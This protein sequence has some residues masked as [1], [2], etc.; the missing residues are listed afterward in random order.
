MHRQIDLNESE[1]RLLTSVLN[2]ISDGVMVSNLDGRF[3]LMNPAA[4]R[5]TGINQVDE[6]KD[7][8]TLFGC[9]SPDGRTLLDSDKLP[10]IR[11]MHGESTDEIEM[12][13]KNPALS[14]AITIEISGKPLLSPDGIGHIGGIIVFR[15]ITSRR[16]IEDEIR[17]SQEELQQFAYIAAHDLQEPLRTITGYLSLLT[18][19][20][21]SLLQESNGEKYVTKAV[22]GARRMQTL[23]EDLLTYAR[24]SSKQHLVGPVNLGEII[25]TVMADLSASIH[26][27][28]TTIKMQKMPRV[29]ADRSQLR[30]LFQNIISNSIKYRAKPPEIEITATPYRAFYKISVADNGIGFE[31]EYANRIFLIFQRLHG[32]TQY[33]GTGI[34]LAICKRIIEKHGGEI[35]VESALGKGTT[36]HFTLPRTPE[37]GG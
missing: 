22:E 37:D 25:A 1:L 13:L 14:T 4:R 28:G 16:N 19:R 6:N 2:S 20:C 24:I 11:A 32:R 15:D 35:W 29:L 34:G 10:L 31:M 5:I 17:R 18:E 9:Y 26:E 3:V 21:A 7:W 36:F 8:S 23:I 12:V 30:Q 27:T 33:D